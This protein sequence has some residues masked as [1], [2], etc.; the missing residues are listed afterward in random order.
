M[1]HKGWL[2]RKQ[3]LRAWI[4]LRLRFR[5]GVCGVNFPF[6]KILF[7]SIFEEEPQKFCGIFKQKPRLRATEEDEESNTN[8]DSFYDAVNVF[9]LFV[10]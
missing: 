6:P 10:S 1:K 8:I 9:P 7:D 5:T 2:Q 3:R 4:F